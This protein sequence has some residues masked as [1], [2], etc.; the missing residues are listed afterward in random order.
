MTFKGQMIGELL[1]S[2][3]TPGVP[4]GI[5]GICERHQM[6]DV[7]IGGIFREYASVWVSPTTRFDAA[8]A[9]VLEFDRSRRLFYEDFLTRVLAIAVN[10]SPVLPIIAVIVRELRRRLCDHNSGDQGDGLRNSRRGGWILR[11]CGLRR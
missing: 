7:Q 5:V 2:V 1:F 6:V 3:L 4:A 9:I 10:V 8:H 11:E